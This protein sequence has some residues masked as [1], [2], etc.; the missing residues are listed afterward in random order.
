MTK[1]QKEFS[2]FGQRENNVSFLRHIMEM[3]ADVNK[4]NPNGQ[5]ALFNAAK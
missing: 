1:M 5:G 3:G 2:P 4:T